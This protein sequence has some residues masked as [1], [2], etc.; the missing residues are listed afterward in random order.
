MISCVIN[1]DGEIMIKIVIF[2]KVY[3][4][5]DKIPMFCMQLKYFSNDDFFFNLFK[6]R[7][8]A[9]GTKATVYVSVAIATAVFNVS[10]IKVHSI[11]I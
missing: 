6:N 5:T 8:S 7:I 1:E 10:L 4:A 2:L 11:R 9:C 3:Y